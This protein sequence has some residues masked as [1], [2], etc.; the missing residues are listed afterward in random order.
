MQAWCIL[1]LGPILAWAKTRIYRSVLAACAEHPLVQLGIRY[2]PSAVVADCA[3]FHADAAGPGA[4]ITFTIE[5]L[6]RAEIVRV[7]AE[8]C[9]DRDLEFY[10]TTNLV[11]RG[12]VGISLFASRVPDHTTLER[13][14]VWIRQHTPDA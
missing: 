1:F 4:P 2:D 14:H 10:L 5:Q 8:S 7:W 3:G 9:S 13:F 11:G 6:V 12:F